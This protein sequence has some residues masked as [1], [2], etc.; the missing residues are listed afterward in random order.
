M[1]VFSFVDVLFIEEP[2]LAADGGHI[3]HG[4]GGHDLFSFC[5]GSGVEVYT[6][7][8]FAGL[9]RVVEHGADGASID[10]LYEGTDCVLRGVYI[11]PS[12][13]ARGWDDYA[14]HWVG[15]NTLFGDFNAHHPYWDAARH[16]NHSQVTWTKRFIDDHG[17]RVFVPCTPTFRGISTFDLCLFV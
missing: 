12:T 2:L 16:N 8:C 3:A 17:Y 13:P 15:C 5:F 14:S 11:P 10:Y 9:F 4:N 6:C 7:S 1:K